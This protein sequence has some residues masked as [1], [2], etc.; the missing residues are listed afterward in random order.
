MRKEV[1]ANQSNRVGHGTAPAAPIS[2]RTIPGRNLSSIEKVM[3]FND[4]S[5]L[6]HLLRILLEQHESHISVLRCAR[7]PLS[8]GA[9]FSGWT[10]SDIPTDS[11]SYTFSAMSRRRSLPWLHGRF[12]LWE[13]R[14]FTTMIQLSQSDGST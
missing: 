13:R 7:R 14:N 6:F 12:S 3:Y 4:R 5:P 10:I 2:A 8:A 1:E 11:L 9:I